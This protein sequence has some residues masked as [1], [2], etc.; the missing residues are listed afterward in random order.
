MFDEK[1]SKQTNKLLGET[2]VK[3]KHLLRSTNLILRA[4]GLVGV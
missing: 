3:S 2:V 1:E 4:L